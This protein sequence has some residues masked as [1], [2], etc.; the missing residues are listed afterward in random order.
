MKKSALVCLLSMTSSV[1]MASDDDIGWSWDEDQHR[2]YH[3]HSDV[4]LPIAFQLLADRNAAARIGAFTVD[5]VVDCTPENI[6]KKAWDL[7][8]TV[9]DVA[10]LAS[11]VQQDQGNIGVILEEVDEKLT[12]ATIDLVMRHDGRVSD[13]D[14]D[15]LAIVDNNRRTHLME[16]TIRI[17]GAR[18][19]AGMDLQL[20]KDGTA[21]W[22][23]RSTPLL[24]LPSSFGGVAYATAEHRLVGTDGSGVFIESMGEGS[25]AYDDQNTFQGSMR[26]VAVFDA[27]DGALRERRWVMQA[28]P[29]A[30]SA[31]ADAWSNIIYAQS[32]QVRR[33]VD[34]ES[35]ALGGSLEGAI[36]VAN[37]LE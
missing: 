13:V 17:M 16:E 26:S 14:I 20:S 2:R 10:L 5:L 27:D 1:A 3:L 32:G 37:A 24:Q 21:R 15:E 18:A 36:A 6:R 7:E 29:T 4:Q 19:F 31:L 12:G 9:E 23:Q 8:C 33:L 25:M 34:G 22:T 35:V 30:G 28:A 11:A